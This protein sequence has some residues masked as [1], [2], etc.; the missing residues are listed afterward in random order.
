MRSS[1]GT[2]VGIATLW[3]GSVD[4]ECALPLWC[5]QARKLQKHLPPPWEARLV[6]MA[7]QQSAECPD[8]EFAWRNETLTGSTEYLTRLGRAASEGSWAYLRSAVMLK[9]QMFALT[10]FDLV[11]YADV[12]VDLA[13]SRG[14]L[15]APR[16]FNATATAFLLSS[17]LV[18]SSPD[19]ASPSNTGVLLLKPRRWLYNAALH[20]MRRGSW[21]TQR[22]FDGVGKPIRLFGYRPALLAQLEAGMLDGSK[23]GSRRLPGMQASSLLNRTE[24]MRGNTWAFTGGNLDQGSFWHLLYHV[25]GVGTWAR[26]SGS[27]SVDHF[28]GPMKPWTKG[29]AAAPIYLKRLQLPDQPVTR[30]QIFLARRIEVRADRRAHQPHATV[31]SPQSL[32]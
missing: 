27:W 15:P 3:D 12:D 11:L 24:M 9:W 20:L 32:A 10:Q 21:T 25:H 1:V 16:E 8:A 28:W 13:P 14:R 4:H 2:R 19:H 5:Q 23:E 17:A 30:C 31:S 18:V 6:I 22:G 26:R 29:G 7:P